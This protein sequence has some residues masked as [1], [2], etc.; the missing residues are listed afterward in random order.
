M[1]KLNLFPP[2]DG[3][4]VIFG[5]PK[6]KAEPSRLLQIEDILVADRQLAK[7]LLYDLRQDEAAQQAFEAA[8]AE[9]AKQQATTQLLEEPRTATPS[10]SP[11][12]A[13]NGSYARGYC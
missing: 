9:A 2:E 8:Q 13:T 11:I 5:V 7:E 1:V 12:A 3:M 10:M 4:T 6:A